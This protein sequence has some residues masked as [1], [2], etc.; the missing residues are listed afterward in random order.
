MTL[1]RTSR[2]VPEILAELRGGLVVSCQ[3][4]PDEA[5]HGA[6]IMKAMALA[7]ITGGACGVRIE[8]LADVR[9]VAEVTDVPIIGL[10]KRGHEGVY[11]TPTLDSA[12]QVAAAGASIV[13]IDG[14]G[15]P[16]P[17]GLT[18]AQ[19]IAALHDMGVAVMADVSTVSEGV[20]AA[21]YG[22]DVVGS[23]LSGYTE[24]SLA[25]V[26]PDLEL[27][28]SLVQRLEVPVFA[29]GRISTPEQARAALAVGAHTVVV[30][31]AITRPA[32]ITA[33]FLGALENSMSSTRS[34]DDRRR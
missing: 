30:G 25:T 24:T 23:T 1:T 5:L 26:G 12:Q 9:A 21:R 34:A 2:G 6:E 32:Q 16:R 10:W 17:D 29:E 19:T 13:A 18:V 20:D 22:A 7:V 27:V 31:G 33:R 15:R 3:A 4:R 11:I 14:T 8:G 28:A